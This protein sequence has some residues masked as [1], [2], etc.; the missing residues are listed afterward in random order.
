MNFLKTF[1]VEKPFSK[2]F[3]INKRFSKT[4][5]IEKP[6]LRIFSETFLNSAVEGGGER[7]LASWQAR[8]CLCPA[9]VPSLALANGKGH[10]VWEMIIVVFVFVVVCCIF[11]SYSWNT[12]MTHIHSS[13][14]WVG[15][16]LCVS[17]VSAHSLWNVYR[18]HVMRILQTASPKVHY[19]SR[20]VGGR[21]DQAGRRYRQWTGRRIVLSRAVSIGMQAGTAYRRW[22][23]QCDGEVEREKGLVVMHVL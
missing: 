19:G 4:F 9:T 1:S 17:Q 3:S 12:R 6:F 7:R 22:T 5:S 11:F 14:L 2:T 16:G 23:G 8:R 21:N 15:L 20:R 10:L 18:R 13:S